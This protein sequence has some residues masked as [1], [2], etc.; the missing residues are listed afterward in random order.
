MGTNIIDNAAGSDG[1]SET[2]TMLTVVGTKVINN[3]ASSDGVN[4]LSITPVEY[5]HVPVCCVV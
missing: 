4:M 1:I 2:P 5:R 3:A